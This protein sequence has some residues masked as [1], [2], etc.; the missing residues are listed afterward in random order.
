VPHWPWSRRLGG[1]AETKQALWKSGPN[2]GA[3]WGAG[4]GPRCCG[5]RTH[6]GSPTPQPQEGYLGGPHRNDQNNVRGGLRLRGLGGHRS[7]MGRAPYRARGSTD[8]VSYVVWN[9]PVPPLP[10]GPRSH[11]LQTGR[12]QRRWRVAVFGSRARRGMNNN[13][14]PLECSGDGGVT[15]LCHLGANGGWPP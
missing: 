15:R 2:R 12:R 3:E 7:A 5:W 1:P 14:P 13:R 4:W 10:A 9:P 11:G 8:P 6:T